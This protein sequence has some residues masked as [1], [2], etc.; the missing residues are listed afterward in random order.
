VWLPFHLA[1]FGV[2]KGK[3]ELYNKGDDL[4]RRVNQTKE[5]LE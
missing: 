5:E 1:T 4:Y 3:A 2:K